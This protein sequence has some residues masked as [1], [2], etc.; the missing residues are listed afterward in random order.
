[1]KGRPSRW[2]LWFPCLFVL[3]AALMPSGAVRADLQPSGPPLPITADPAGA[4]LP[5]VA[6]DPSGNFV[7]AWFSQLAEGDALR[8]RRFD[9]SGHPLGPEIQVAVLR[10]GD[11]VGRPRIA[12]GSDGRMVVVWHEITGVRARRLAADGQP[13]GDVIQVSE[14]YCCHDF[15]DVVFLSSGD[16]LVAWRYPYISTMEPLGGEDE[17]ILARLFDAGGA[18][19]GGVFQ[20]SD[21][22]SPRS[23]LRL[24]ADPAGG[25]AA[26]WENDMYGSRGGLAVTVRRFTGDG[27]PRGPEIQVT[28]DI[29]AI[30]PVPL[31][32]PGGELSV[33]WS[34]LGATV[35]RAGIFAQRFTGDGHLLGPKIQVADGPLLDAPPDAVADRVGHRLV[36]WAA[37]GPGAGSPAEIHA[38]L[39][40]SAWHPLQ[41][42]ATAGR[43]IPKGVLVAGALHIFPPW[44]VA[45]SGAAGFLTLW[46]GLSTPA[47][48]LSQ[49][50]GQLL[51]APCLAGS[52]ELCQ[53]G[54]RFHVEVTWHDP[55]S[56]GRGTAK[57]RPLT[58]DT[59]A[60]WFFSPGNAELLVKVLDGRAVNG[61][62]WVF[63]G[64]LTDLEYDL[65]VTDTQTGARQVY[66]NPPYT[67][68]SRA[69]I[70]AFAD[71]GPPAATEPAALQPSDPSC[72]AGAC[73]GAFQVTVEWNDP[74]TG[75]KHQA[76]GVPLSGDS[77]YFWFFAPGNLELV[78]KVLDGHAVNGHW[79]VFY[80]ALTNVEYT[81]RVD[82]PDRH[83][84]RSYHNPKGHMES[85]ADTL[86]F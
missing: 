13:V 24:A 72:P 45:A 38:L 8:V 77:A 69:D 39:V 1:M 43:F 85:R 55:R 42:T 48:I 37:P 50:T 59:G 54:D 40:D 5:A 18:P 6:S 63:F 64:A 4:V 61:H 25:F 70:K 62:W 73:L 74:A 19:R 84:S 22:L 41:P 68:A 49:V 82:W 67:L 35:D 11:W 26:A 9:A 34:D 20:L 12:V 44:P 58:G 66:H 27:T 36:V 32:T 21:S 15:P 53:N 16:F 56:G 51:T 52:T 65:T 28:G 30:N 2:K 78:V 7:V 86:A 75:Q 47:G 33:V 31:F 60:F 23:Q 29:E 10:P 57:A 80:G 46:D 83:L 79:W 76:A 14:P 81:L 17:P 3:T 71:A